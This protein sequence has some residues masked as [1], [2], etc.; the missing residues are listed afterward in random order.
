MKKYLMTMVGLG[1]M[2]VTLGAHAE[3]PEPTLTPPTPSADGA[4]GARGEE[5]F[6]PGPGGGEL[7]TGGPP[8]LESTGL[9]DGPGSCK[10]STAVGSGRW[11]S[12][13][14]A[15]IGLAFGLGLV[16]AARRRSKRAC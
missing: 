9:E 14:S 13:S 2:I 5:T 11:S 16:A 10:C 3:T 4:A 7:E 12:S 1:C 6:L 8:P 15:W